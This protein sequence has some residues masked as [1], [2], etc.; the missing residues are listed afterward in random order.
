MA[1]VQTQQVVVTAGAAQIDTAALSRCHAQTP[2]LGIKLFSSG[3]VWQA[4][5]NTAQ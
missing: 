2:G 1:G 5:F 4:N 3:Y